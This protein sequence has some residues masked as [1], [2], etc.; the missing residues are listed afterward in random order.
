MG[1]IDTRTKFCEDLDVTG[2]AGTALEGD[3][4]PLVQARD[5]GN[6]TTIYVRFVVTE[7]FSTGSSPT[8]NLQ[9]VS[10]AAAAIATDGSA[11]VHAQTGALATS[12][13]TLGKSFVMALP[14]EG[15]AYE[16]YLGV[17]VVT[18]VAATTT[19]KL[20][21]YLTPDPVGWK[22]YAEAAS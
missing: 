19:G 6:G 15:V 16:A 11:S 8:V 12:E 17:L 20:T 10:D 4:I 14:L 1:I 18:A 2:S 21:A 7:A 3:Q 22:A 9:L 5:I 13:L